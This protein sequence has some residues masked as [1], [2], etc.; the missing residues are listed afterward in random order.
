MFSQ[1]VGVKGIK[2]PE[3]K[4][5]PEQGTTP[6]WVNTDPLI[7]TRISKPMAANDKRAKGVR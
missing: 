4:G 2:L 7:E 6:E 5:H 3:Q 1:E